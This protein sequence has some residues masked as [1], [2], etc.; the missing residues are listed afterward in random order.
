MNIMDTSVND[1]AKAREAD[2]YKIVDYDYGSS[3]STQFKFIF[4][5]LYSYS[6]I[7]IL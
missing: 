3:V 4:F 6:I 1:K 7:N 2:K 5:A